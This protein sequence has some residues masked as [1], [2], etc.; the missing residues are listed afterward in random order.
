MLQFK[1]LQVRS[2][3]CSTLF[4]GLLSVPPAVLGH[5]GGVDANGCHYE[6]SRGK[7]WQDTYHC[8]EQRPPNRD[9]SA[10]VRKSRENICHDASSSNY[11]QLQYFVPYK[12]MKQCTSSG[13]RAYKG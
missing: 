2:L 3:F 8:H 5:P 4:A 11:N 12:S 1:G 7:G 10:P 9:R 6:R 13:G